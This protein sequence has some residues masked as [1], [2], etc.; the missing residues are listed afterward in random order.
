MWLATADV[1]RAAGL[2]EEADTSVA[3]ALG[4]D[5]QKGNVAAAGRLVSPERTDASQTPD[6]R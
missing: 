2:S 1:Q 5:K 3:D 6:V 4:L